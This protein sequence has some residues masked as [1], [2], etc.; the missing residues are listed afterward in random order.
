MS[1]KVI[2]SYLKDVKDELYGVDNRTILQEITV[3]IEDKVEE[4]CK[5]M[6]LKEP[7]DNVYKLIIKDFGSP[8][9]V[10]RP[11]KKEM[12]LILPRQIRFYLILQ[13]ITGFIA[14]LIFIEGMDLLIRGSIDTRTGFL[15]TQII[16]NLV[17]LLAFI[18]ITAIVIVQWRKPNKVA[19]LGNIGLVFSLSII[20]VVLFIMIRV[21]AWNQWELEF[22]ENTYYPVVTLIMILF[23]FLYIIGFQHMERLNRR[24]SLSEIHG[25]RI[26]MVRKRTRKVLIGVTSVFIALLLLFVIGQSYYSDDYYES[27]KLLRTELI[28][29]PYDAQLQLWEYHGKDTSWEERK[30]VYHIDDEREEGA[31]FPEMQ[32]ALDW[33]A[34]STS[35]DSTIMSWWDYGHSIRGY[36]A[37]NVVLDNPIEKAKFT[38]ADSSSI[39]E[40]E[41]DEMKFTNVANALISTDSNYTAD[42]MNMYGSQFIMTNY[43]DVSSISYAIIDA[44][45]MAASEYETQLDDDSFLYQ[46]WNKGNIDG[47]E[48]VYSDLEV[49]ILMIS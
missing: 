9:E 6:D 13:S 5:E 28:G 44:A 14:L 30:I 43:R 49:K 35:A 27:E 18:I 21:I 15:L 29:G 26:R 20:M 10:A 12:P 32:N 41:T 31:F 1:S 47:F 34:G 36:T 38:L 48:V 39:D 8:E 7:D 16:S 4:Y 42:I 24:L 19:Y 37:R 33:I 22:N 11:Y 45:N 23:I 2:E 3:H 46:V 40:W 17:F 25:S